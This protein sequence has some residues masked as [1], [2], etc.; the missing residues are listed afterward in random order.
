ME[1]RAVEKQKLLFYFWCART[2]SQVLG[3]SVG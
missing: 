1:N 2:Q 3:V